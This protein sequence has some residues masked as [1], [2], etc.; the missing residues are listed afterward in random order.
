MTSNSQLSVFNK[1]QPSTSHQRPSLF[2]QMRKDKTPKSSVFHRM[3]GDKQPKPSV[4]TRIKTGGKCSSSLP[5]Q[6]RNSVF[7]H[8]GEVNEVQS[9][10]SSCMKYISTLDIKTDDSLKV[11]KHTLVI[12]SCEASSNL[13]EKNQGGWASLF[14]PCHNSRA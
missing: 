7:S 2:S 9:S 13:K 14:S 6:D 5:V 8:L 3:R 11:K 4:L 10:I 12:T 1:L